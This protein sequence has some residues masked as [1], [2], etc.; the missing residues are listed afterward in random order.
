MKSKLE[1]AKEAL[2]VMTM[3]ATEGLSDSEIDVVFDAREDIEEAL[4]A[5]GTTIPT[6]RPMTF[7]ESVKGLGLSNGAIRL[8]L[9][10]RAESEGAEEVEFPKTVAEEYD[11]PVAS[12]RRYVDELIAKGCISRD[13]RAGFG[14]ANIYRFAKKV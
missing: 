14:G 5:L 12:L 4:A 11:I 2:E 1:K 9:C 13:S 8:L 6:A 10:M 7:P 3:Y